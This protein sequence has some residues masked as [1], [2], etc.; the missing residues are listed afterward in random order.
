MD[1]Y[2]SLTSTPISHKHGQGVDLMQ[3]QK[4][5][6]ILRGQW[7]VFYVLGSMWNCRVLF[8]LLEL[9]EGMATCSLMHKE[10]L[11]WQC[12]V[13][14]PPSKHILSCIPGKGKLFCPHASPAAEEM[15]ALLL[16][17]CENRVQ[18]S[19]QRGEA[20]GA[21]IHIFDLCTNFHWFRSLF[22]SLF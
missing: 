16:D 3:R 2:A 10:T 8:S 13:L 4:S 14:W 6:D 17:L 11:L 9:N 7:S 21:V 12:G 15:C 1:T 18:I 5:T 19:H 20:D 22:M